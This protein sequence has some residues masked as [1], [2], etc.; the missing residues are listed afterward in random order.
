MIDFKGAKAYII[1][2]LTNELNPD[3][4]YHSIAHTIDVYHA[5]TNLAKME[6]VSEKDLLLVQTAA[7][8]HDAGL[9]IKY[10]EHEQISCSFVKESLPLYGYKKCDI[11]TICQMILATRIPQEPHTLL[12][13][14]LCDADL[15]YMG[16]DDFFMNAMRLKHE[17][18]DYGIITSLKQW[19][20][21]Q[22]DFLQKHSYFTNSA[23]KLRQEKKLIH[24]SQIKE[25][26]AK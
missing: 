12:D 17:W 18:M 23:I 9:L 26:M 25:M 7:L 5:A 22:I 24:L 3:L 21:I 19:Y 8:Y 20:L 13:K 4:K 6:Q 15:D 11:K 2:K 16:R 1:E 10:R 14:I